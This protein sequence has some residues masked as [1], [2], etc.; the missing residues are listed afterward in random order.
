MT[1]GEHLEHVEVP[2][3]QALRSWLVEHHDQQ[4]GVWIVTWKKHVPERHVTHEQVL[5]QL[6]AFGWTDGILRRIDED[7]TRQLVS[8]RRAKPWAKSYKDRAERLITEGRMHVSGLAAVERAR[9]TGMWD[10]MNDVDALQVPDDLAEA[11]RAQP[12]AAGNFDA[13]P[14][15]ARRSI[16]RWIASARTPATRARRIDRTVAD[17]HRNVRVKSHG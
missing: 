5:D 16:L 14:P 11:L 8:P 3:E 12:P 17:A 1:A 13:F 6:I 7:R 15:S 2:S 9:A 10:V 4:A